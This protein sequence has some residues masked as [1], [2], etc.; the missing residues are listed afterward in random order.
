MLLLALGFSWVLLAT[1][2]LSLA[3]A[4]AHGD[5]RLLIT[6]ADRH[7]PTTPAIPRRQTFMGTVDYEVLRAHRYE[8]PLAIGVLEVHEADESDMAEVALRL[9]GV[10]RHSDVLGRLADNQIAVLMPETSEPEA[11]QASVR[12]LAEVRERP[13][14]GRAIEISIGV[15]GLHAGD[16]A[17]MVLRRADDALFH[18]RRAGSGAVGAPPASET[19]LRG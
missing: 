6:D 8:R 19:L 16:T 11:L 10:V 2:V 14:R 7:V 5:A 4:A 13:V 15:S 17:A 1:A 9:D 18:V 3:R 12:L